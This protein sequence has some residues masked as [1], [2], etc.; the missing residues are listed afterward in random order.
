MKIGN[1]KMAM[2][3]SV[4]AFT[5]LLVCSFTSSAGDWPMWRYDAERS[6]ASPGGIAANPVL[7]WSE[8]FHLR[9]K[10]GRS[11]STRE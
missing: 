6:A 9:D 11:R 3:R 5:F 10:P 2:L 1:I 4:S 7:L 8:S